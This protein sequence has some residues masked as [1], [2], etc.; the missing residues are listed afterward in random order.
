MHVTCNSRVSK[1]WLVC[2]CMHGGTNVGVISNC[3]I[4]AERFLLFA[5]Q[6]KIT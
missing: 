1:Q 5:M 2:V 4:D 3:G 6:L